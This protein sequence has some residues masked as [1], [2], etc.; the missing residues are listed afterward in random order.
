[1][2]NAQES[3][4]SVTPLLHQFTLSKAKHLPSEIDLACYTEVERI[5]LANEYKHHFECFGN[6]LQYFKEEIVQFAAKWGCI[7]YLEKMISEQKDA[8]AF[9]NSAG[10]LRIACQ[11]GRTNMVKFL[12]EKYNVNIN[13]PPVSQKDGYPIHSAIETH[14][15]E[16]VEILLQNKASLCVPN[17]VNE[18][19]LQQTLRQMKVSGKLV[20]DYVPI[21][22]LIVSHLNTVDLDEK[23]PVMQQSIKEV[24]SQIQTT[25]ALKD[26][27]AL[28]LGN[29]SSLGELS[30][31]F[32]N[33]H[34]RA[35]IDDI[36]CSL[37]ALSIEANNATNSARD[38]TVRQPGTSSR[39]N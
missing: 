21:L 26:Q 32:D 4:E 22:N 1:M 2:I 20:P 37:A 9:L 29:A 35:S 30:K 34:I 28:I 33:C 16:I 17:W 25:P 3:P 24:M 23:N 6:N 36:L 15:L 8:S 7:N 12:I 39:L 38:N 18:T 19:P 13:Q 10:A 5:Q 11:F 27:I 31:L 14:N